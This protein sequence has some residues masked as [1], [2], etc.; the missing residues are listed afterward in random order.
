MTNSADFCG[1]FNLSVTTTAEV[2]T[3][4]QPRLCGVLGSTFDVTNLGD[5]KTLVESS[6]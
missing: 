4:Y 6:H 3:R 2:P 1:S 5:M